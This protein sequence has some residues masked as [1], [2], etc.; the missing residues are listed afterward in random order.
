MDKIESEGSC[1]RVTMKNWVP[2]FSCA[3]VTVMVV[4]EDLCWL[5]RGN[6]IL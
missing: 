4:D 3:F 1:L 6:K 2:V 5:G